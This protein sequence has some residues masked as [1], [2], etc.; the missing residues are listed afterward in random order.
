MHLLIS[1]MSLVTCPKYSTW[2]SSEDQRYEIEE[3]VI[4]SILTMFNVHS[5][6]ACL[7]ICIFY[8]RFVSIGHDKVNHFQRLSEREDLSRLS[9]N[10]RIN[11]RR[12][13]LQINIKCRRNSLKNPLFVLYPIFKQRLYLVVARTASEQNN[14]NFTLESFLQVGT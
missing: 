1:H 12:N 2:S 8:L 9:S 6:V 11:G 13:H 5:S 3:V 10:C 7:P 4:L 14:S